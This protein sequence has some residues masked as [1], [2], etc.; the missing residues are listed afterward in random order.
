MQQVDALA[1]DWY[2]QYVAAREAEPGDAIGWED[3]LSDAEAALN[4][5][6]AL[7]DD[8]MT[9]A[10]RFIA[11]RGLHLSPLSMEKFEIAL[12]R[13]YR[14]AAATL[15]RRSEGDRSRDAHLDRLEPPNGPVGAQQAP[16]LA[17]SSGRVGSNGSAVTLLAAYAADRGVAPSTLRRWEPVMV[18]LDTQPW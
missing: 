14:A 15:L 18:A 11:D 10:E 5:D 2:R 16:V 9:D 3:A 12:A 13:E 1:G 6:T 7:P 17:V 8:V 4:G